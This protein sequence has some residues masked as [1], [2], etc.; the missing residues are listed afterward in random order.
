[1][2]ILPL[3]TLVSTVYEL[4]FLQFVN[5]LLSVLQIMNPCLIPIKVDVQHYLLRY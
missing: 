1:M 2:L 4:N 3:N 5:L